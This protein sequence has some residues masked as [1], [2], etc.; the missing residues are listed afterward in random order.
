MKPEET[1]YPIH[2]KELLAVI[3]GIKKW[4][5]ELRSVKEFI[6]ITDHKNLKYF[7]KKQV[8]TER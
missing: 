2:D 6:I 7:A 1:N 3:D 8:L 4:R 5:S